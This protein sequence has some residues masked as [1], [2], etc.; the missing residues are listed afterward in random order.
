MTA[1]SNTPSTAKTGTRPVAAIKSAGT[2]SQASVPR[3]PTSPSRK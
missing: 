2:T 3:K 1:R